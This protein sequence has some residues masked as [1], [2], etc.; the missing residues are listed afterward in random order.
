MQIA[1]RINRVP[2]AKIYMFLYFGRTSIQVSRG[3]NRVMPPAAGRGFDL[4][5]DPGRM[6]PPIGGATRNPVV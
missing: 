2:T 6:P 4:P 3:C 5:E 1:Y